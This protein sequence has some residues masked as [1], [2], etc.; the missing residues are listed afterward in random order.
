MATTR[1][2]IFDDHPLIGK[3]L[4]DYI[5]E[6]DSSMEIILLLQNKRRSFE[7]SQIK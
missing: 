7:P 6:A 5:L 4:A 2:G 1:I 3:G